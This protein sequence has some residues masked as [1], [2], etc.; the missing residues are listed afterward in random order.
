MNELF[1]ENELEVLHEIGKRLKIFRK[2]RGFTQEFLAA[3]AGFS[4]SYYS[5]IETGKRN[6]SIL[7]LCKLTIALDISL[8]ELLLPIKDYAAKKELEAK[9]ALDSLERS[10]SR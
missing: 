2:I 6:I 9:N 3:K 4:R 5:D 7:N 8:S 1:K 10:C